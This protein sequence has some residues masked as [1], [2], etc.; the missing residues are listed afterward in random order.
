MNNRERFFAL[1]E[2]KPVD[3][4]PFI[5]DISTWYVYTRQRLGEPAM[6]DPGDYI[7]DDSP[8]HQ[9]P[10]RLS[11]KHAKMTFLDYYKEY[12]WCLPVHMYGW[13]SER[14]TGGVE[15]DTR[16]E[17]RKKIVTCRTPKGDL[18]RTYGLAFDGS[19]APIDHFAKSVE[20]LDVLKYVGEHTVFTPLYDK[21]ERFHRETEGYGVC[22]LP[23]MR[24]PFGKL[25]HEFLGF[26]ETVYALYDEE[27]AVEDF[28]A[29]QAEVDMKAIECA[30]QSAA[31]VVIISDH[32]DENLISPPYYQKY[33]IP[34]Y[35]RAR[36]RLNGAGKYVSTHLDGNFRGYLPFISNAGFDLLDGCTPAPMFNYTVDQLAEATKGGPLC[37]CGVPSTLFTQSSVTTEELVDFG[38]HIA[39]AFEGRVL[40]NVGDVLPANGD[41]DQVIAVGEAVMHYKF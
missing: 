13:L 29:F 41:I 31:H 3:R 2:N 24:S 11:G 10:S 9:L 18:Q 23:I 33:C 19:W 1:M 32:A 21:I 30:A 37:Y 40:V 4:L 8:I 14:Y 28:L 38:K 6:Y 7:P 15:M 34:Y 27:E 35:K 16:I 39:E 26:E 5:P 36:A 20:D 25:I 12:D 22:D 17:G